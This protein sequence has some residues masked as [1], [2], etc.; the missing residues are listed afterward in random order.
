MTW[1]LT[2]VKEWSQIPPQKKRFMCLS[3]PQEG[4]S[5]SDLLFWDLFLLHATDVNF[6]LGGE[7]TVPWLSFVKLQHNMDY[8]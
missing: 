2:V 6:D 4:T 1:G 3:Y 5:V 7:K 8:I